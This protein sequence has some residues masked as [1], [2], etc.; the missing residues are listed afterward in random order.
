MADDRLPEAIIGRLSRTR[1]IE[2]EFADRLD[3]LA[4][5]GAFDEAGTEVFTRLAAVAARH[6]QALEEVAI[7]RGA[8]LHGRE[9]TRGG[10][11]HEHLLSAQLEKAIVAAASAVIAYDALYASARLLYENE[12]C[13]LADA[14]AAEVGAR[15]IRAQRPVGTGRPRRARLSGNDV[16][17]HLPDLWHRCLRVHAQQRQDDPRALG[18]AR[19][20]AR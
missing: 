3:Q 18:P 20:G 9:T 8:E 14:H 1:T 16:P 5:A 15:A 11:E 4:A 6:R 12:V 7:R 10:R 19:A 17:M 2:S 13:D